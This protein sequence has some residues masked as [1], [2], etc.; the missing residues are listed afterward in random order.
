MGSKK[1]KTSELFKA[2][3]ESTYQIKQVLDKHFKSE[4]ISYQQYVLLKVIEER[5]PKP[6]SIKYIKENMPDKNSD[7]TRIVDKLVVKNLIFKDK[8]PVDARSSVAS[9]RDEAF[10]LIEK[11]DKRLNQ[12]SKSLKFLTKKDRQSLFEMISKVNKHF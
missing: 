9:L 3:L 1:V 2:L 12:I 5:H 4:V 10:P 11:L 7:V 8:S 6:L